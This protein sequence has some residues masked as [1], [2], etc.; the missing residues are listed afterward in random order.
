MPH[1]VHVPYR[2][3][4]SEIPNRTVLIHLSARKTY[5]RPNVGAK[6]EV[7]GL[8]N[9]AEDFKNA[10]GSAPSY[11]NITWDRY[12]KHMWARQHME[13]TGLDNGCMIHMWIGCLVS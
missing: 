4:F 11:L 10:G 3:K 1:C 12:E 2:E 13:Y 5:Q 8:V 6:G 7:R 9:D